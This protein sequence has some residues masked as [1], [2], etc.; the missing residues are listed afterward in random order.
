[1]HADLSVWQPPAEAYDLISAHYLHLPPDE[2]P[3]FF[4]RL[5]RAMR[6]GGTLLFV[7]H[8]A[9]DLETSVGRPAVPDLYFT[10]EDVVAALVP[11]RWEVLVG[12][13]L[14][15]HVTNRAG[16]AITIH[17]MVLKARRID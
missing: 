12:G 9:S 6:P 2:R 8:H 11:G 1:V 4:G 14:P 15:R 5:A 17:D 7:A 3:A 10:S 13:T 16:E